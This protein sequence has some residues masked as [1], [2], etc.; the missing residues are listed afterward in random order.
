MATA[1]AM[2]FA[3]P[4]LSPQAGQPSFSA[5]RIKCIHPVPCTQVTDGHVVYLL[6]PDQ[7]IRLP[8]CIELCETVA[9]IALDAR[10][11][12]REF[13]NTDEGPFWEV[14]GRDWA[15]QVFDPLVR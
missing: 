7:S 13:L 5:L 6:D 11:R 14:S 3:C 10:H 2:L 12:F 15:T 4:I 8:D 1:A 9:D